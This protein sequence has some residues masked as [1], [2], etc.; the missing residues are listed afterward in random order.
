VSKK[1][2]VLQVIPTLAMGGISSVVM[3]WYR[4]INHDVYQFDF[5]VF[6]EGILR[7]EIGSL[8]GNIYLLPTLRKNP[9]KYY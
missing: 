9:I 2:K 8:G 4:N 6:N 3:N 7:E 1:L 5:V